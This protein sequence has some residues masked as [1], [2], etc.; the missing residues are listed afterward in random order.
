MKPKVSVAMITYGHEKY[1]KEAI[2][3]VLMQ[4]C[5]FEIELIVANDKSPDKTEVVVMDIIKNHPNGHWIKYTRHE[6]NKGMMP[7]FMWSLEQC[8]GQYIALCEGDDYW[9]DPSKLQ[10]QVDLMEA[11][12]DC[13]L[14]FHSAN[15]INYYYK[16]LGLHGPRI[17]Q[18][19][20]FFDIK[21]AI[22]QASTLIPTN[23]M[24]FQAKYVKGELPVWFK[25]APVG[26]IPLMLLL[27]RKGKLGFINEVMSNYRIMTHESWT[28]Q[29]LIDKRKRV[30]HFFKIKKMW[31]DFNEWTKGDY[32][33]TV[34]KK[35][36]R[37][38]VFFILYE[39]KLKFNHLMVKIKEK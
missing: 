35:Q 30:E 38:T 20:E 39:V 3:G 16:V 25:E 17:K 7:N 21:D 23:A 11:N 10:K 34:Y 26:D 18:T 2:E 13:T 32:R 14:V 22:L 37:N 6:D 19:Y 15:C 24:L 36:I 1:I 5:D 12:T 31:F 27:A 33:I 28:R 29:V 8:E 4:V 9:I